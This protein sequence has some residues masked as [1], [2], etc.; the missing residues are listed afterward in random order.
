MKMTLLPLALF[1]LS[2]YS[3][4]FEFLHWWTSP[5]ERAALEVLESHLR[6]NHLSVHPSAVIGG[7]GDSAMTV[8]QARA[9]AGNTPS[10]A[11]IEGP[12]I[13][14]W[15]AIGILH[16]INHTAQTMKWDEV[17]YPLAIDIN[18]TDN[19]YVALPLTLH[20]LNL[21]WTNQK[22]L[23]QLNLTTPTTWP[24]LFNAMEQAKQAGIAP[25]AI[26]EQPWQIA[27]LFESLVIAAGGVTFYKTALV[28]LD[29]KNIDSAEMR[30]ALSQLRHISLLTTPA[31]KQSKWD[32]ATQ[33]LAE[34]K[35]LFQLG[36]DWILGDLLARNISVP[37]HISCHPA[38]QSHQIFLYNMDSFIFMASKTFSQ[39]QA[40]QLSRVLADKAFQQRFN[41]VKGSIPVRIDIDLNHFNDCQQ[42]SYHDFQ[43]ASANGLAVPSMTDSMAV[44]P[45]AQ[46]AINS[47]IFR[48]FRNPDIS[49]NEVIRRIL[50]ISVN[51]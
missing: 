8:L 16:P 14:S 4:T 6:Q 10:F 42:Q 22:L 32:S 13:K 12:S 5:G 9:L 29:K 18:K 47:E 27:Q 3:Q 11:Q 2:V 20:R 41:R 25:L 17:L 49:E 33:A 35:A 50:S 15:D 39:P 26:G 48:F 30:L 24:E 23:K 1:P 46:Q 38:P 51:H 21:L 37:E 31:S 40:E 19:G 28:Q 7:G 36:G 34:D 45:V 43:F 44:N